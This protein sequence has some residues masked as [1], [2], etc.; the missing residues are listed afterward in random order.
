MGGKQDFPEG[1]RPSEEFEVVP[2][3]SPS[4]NALVAEH[5]RKMPPL[6]ARGLVYLLVAVIVVALVYSFFG[7]VDIVVECP[8]VARPVSGEVRVLSDRTGYLQSVFVAEGQEVAKNDPLFHIRARE[9][10]ERRAEVSRIK[11]EQTR[12][13]LNS[14][15]SDLAFWEREVQRAAQELSSLEDLLKSGIVSGKEVLDTRSRLEKAQT[16]VKKLRAQREI[17]LNEIKILESQISGDVEESEKTIRAESPGVVLELFFRNPGD[18]IRDSDL[19][20]TIVP[21]GTPLSVDIKV[22]NKDIGFIEKGMIIKFKFDAFP[23]REYGFLSGRVVSVSP[24][25]VD[26]KKLG[27]VYDVQGALDQAHYDI[28]GKRYP[29]KP[30]MTGVAEIVTEKKTFFSMLFKPFRKR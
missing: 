27:Y 13:A 21:V 15:D 6:F 11:L 14:L 29:V 24:S 3:E 5:L 7:S 17:S 1:T 30:G 10:L 2:V 25:S 8:A 16:E 26:D 4:E 23:F 22:A 19:L 12:S 18:Y 9:P 20:C 28:R